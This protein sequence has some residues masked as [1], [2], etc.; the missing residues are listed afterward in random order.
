MLMKLNK[1]EIINLIK[2]NI[3]EFCV[4]EKVYVFGSIL[5]KD[6]YSNDIDVLFLYSNFSSELIKSI[7]KFKVYIEK[8]TFYP[9]DITVLSFEE[10]KEIGFIA[11]LDKKYVCIK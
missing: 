6:K 7:Y 8:K 3:D 11:K 4:F 2:E 9:V 10:E 5:I 1:I